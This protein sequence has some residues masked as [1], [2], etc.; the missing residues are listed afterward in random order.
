MCN[1]LWT[2]FVPHIP[3]PHSVSRPRPLPYQLRPDEMAV[4]SAAGGGDRKREKSYLVNGG[5]GGM[6]AATGGRGCLLERLLSRAL[7]HGGSRRLYGHETSNGHKG[8]SDETRHGLHIAA[9][10]HT[11]SSVYFSR[12]TAD[13]H[14]S[15]RAG[16]TNQMLHLSGLDGH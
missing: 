12:W 13:F 15:L 7:H 1:G 5:R 10:Q 9:R 6:V 8:K 3:H 4:H 14:R 16:H 11:S 2:K